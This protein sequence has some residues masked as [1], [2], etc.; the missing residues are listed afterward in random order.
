MT[1]RK[2]KVAGRTARWVAGTSLSLALAAAPAGAQLFPFHSQRWIDGSAPDWLGIASQDDNLGKSMAAGDFN[3]DGLADLAVSDYENDPLVESGVV[4]VSYSAPGQGVSTDDVVFI[5]ILP[6]IFP[7]PD[8][9]AADHFGE[10]LAVGDFNGDGVDDLAVG[11]PNETVLGQLFAGA[12]V[13]LFGSSGGG[14]TVDGAQRFSLGSGDLAA[15]LPAPGDQLGRALAAGDFNKDGFDDLAVGVP[16]REVTLIG[17]AGMVLVFYGFSSGLA[18]VSLL[19][20]DSQSG[21]VSMAD[22]AEPAD[23]FGHTLAT[24]DFNGDG[25]DDLAIGVPFEDWIDLNDGAVHVVF[26]VP[27][28]GLTLTGNLLWTQGASGIPGTSEAGDNFGFALAAGRFNA[29]G[30]ADLAIGAPG[31]TVGTVFGPQLAAGA[32]TVVYPTGSGHTAVAY[33]QQTLPLDNFP[34]PLDRFGRSLAAG[35]FSGDGLDDLAVGAPGESILTP[36]GEVDGAGSVSVLFGTPSFGLVVGTAQEWWAGFRGSA[37]EPG[38]A[39]AYGEAL[40]AGDFDGTG[41]ADLAIGAPGEARGGELRVGSVYVLYGALFADGF[42][43]G[44]LSRWSAAVP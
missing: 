24:G 8:Q 38:L 36:M 13:V 32:V 2:P 11:V 12:L 42:E 44:D 3:H 23:Q 37:G 39:A 7:L 16:G 15:H 31:E 21:S 28:V 17:S 19:T 30:F 10:A 5:D 26:G 1:I 41:H 29:D 35:D 40:A 33:T 18:P 22:V 25:A 14:L 20:Q 43:S 6:G 4:H 27:N 9:E 34:E